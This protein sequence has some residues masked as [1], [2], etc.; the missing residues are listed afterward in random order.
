MRRRS[1][2]TGTTRKPKMRQGPR[3]LGARVRAFAAINRVRRG[4]SKTL[5]SAARSENTTVKSIRRLLPSAL[6]QDRPGGRI[7][8]KAW[9][10]YSAPV[11]ILTDMG[12]LVVTARGSRQRELAGRH[13][14]TAMR[15]LRNEEP[16]SALHQFRDKS[17]GGHPL[18][19][20]FDLLSA[21]ARAGVLNQLDNLYVTPDTSA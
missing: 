14:A 9:D 4:Q 7:R 8:V 10:R 13:R 1:T 20:D 2:T 21:P 16:A 5:S 15:V 18:I 17:V 19:V 3:I 6:R 11:E 12:P